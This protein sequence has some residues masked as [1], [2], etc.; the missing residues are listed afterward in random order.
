M[1]LVGGFFTTFVVA[2]VIAIVMQPLVAPLLQ[3]DIRTEGDGLAEL[4][5]LAG[6]AAITL[7]LNWLLPRVNSSHVRWRHGARV[8]LALGVTSLPG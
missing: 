2:S 7:V 3:P 8:G 6:C 4:P 1:L 5:L